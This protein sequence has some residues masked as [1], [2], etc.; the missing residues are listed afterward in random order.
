VTTVLL[1]SVKKTTACESLQV[2]KL[3]NTGLHSWWSCTPSL[4]ESS[5]SRAAPHCAHLPLSPTHLTSSPAVGQWTCN[6]VAAGHRTHTHTH[7]HTTPCHSCPQ[8]HSDFLPAM[9]LHS[10]LWVTQLTSFLLLYFPTVVVRCALSWWH[11]FSAL[12][13]PSYEQAACVCCCCCWDCLLWE[14][15]HCW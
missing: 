10:F 6:L 3:E 4:E 2:N 12:L 8:R 5:T 1:A 9:W 15:S 7:I 11:L 14:W 13:K